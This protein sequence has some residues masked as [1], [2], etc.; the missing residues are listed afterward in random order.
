M[1]LNVVAPTVTSP[2]I[3]NV[4]S[5][6]LGNPGSGTTNVDAI[7]VLASD[8]AVTTFNTGSVTVPAVGSS[9]SPSHGTVTIGTGEQA[10]DIL[11][12]P[13]TGFIGSDTFKYSVA[14]NNGQSGSATVT[15]YIGAEISTATTNKV[16]TYTDTDGTN[17][18]V[19]LNRG[20]A[21]LYFSGSGTVPASNN[22]GLLA[23]GGKVALA[24]VGL[25]GTTAASTFTLTGARHGAVT[26]GGIKD[27]SAIGVVSAPTANLAGVAGLFGGFRSMTL[28]TVTGS[29]FDIGPTGSQ[30]TTGA[31]TLNGSLSI[32][33]AVTDTSLNDTVI[34]LNVIKAASWTNTVQDV[35]GSISAPS[36]RT[37]AIAGSFDPSL[38]LTG[39]GTE[40]TSA[41]IR[42]AATT[43]Y[44]NLQGQCHE[45]QPGK[46]H[47][48]LG[49][50][51]CRRIGADI[52]GP[53]RRVLL[54][55]RRRRDAHHLQ[56]QRRTDW[57][58]HG[59]GC[60]HRARHRRGDQRLA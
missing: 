58:D 14:D 23:L 49:R 57:I 26:L 43:G 36:I 31:A 24:D 46:R 33:G 27:N 19:R 48:R 16:V 53:R 4:V 44:W 9:G 11:Y 39:A 34:P 50:P 55:D 35:L 52:R 21:D 12:T 10:G 30:A 5:E 37:L 38:S 60:R 40:L 29:T 56:R 18:T 7:N 1:T 59:R 2:D 28:A 45:H 32:A 6:T 20:T 3:N 25:S 51:Q 13:A 41:T 15:V 22:R 8:V 47:P 42:G 17:V 54:L